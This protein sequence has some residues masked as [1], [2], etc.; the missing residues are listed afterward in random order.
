[1][2]PDEQRDGRAARRC[3]AVRF[4]VLFAAM[5][6]L[7]AATEAELCGHTGLACGVG[8]VEAAIATTRSLAGERPDAV[9]HVGLAGARGLPVGTPVIGREAVYCDLRAA[10]PVVAIA[11]ADAQLLDAARSA[12][13]DAPV[14]PIGTSA[15]VGATPGDV[16]VEAMEGFAVLRAAALAGV[17]ALEVRVISNEIGE[18]DR[19]RWRVDEAL[20]AL[21]QAL[22]ALLTALDGR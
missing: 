4:P 5:L 8:P 6:L 20:H 16:P 12:L 21:A 18:P 1:M 9:L 11:A 3:P 10:I 7:V 14:L 13:P 15:A 17:P 19:G 22:P 2:L